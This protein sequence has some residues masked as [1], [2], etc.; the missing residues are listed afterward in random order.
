MNSYIS[1]SKSTVKTKRWIYSILFLVFFFSTFIISFNF[2]IDPYNITK[3]NILNIKY[4]FARDDRTE[5]LRYFKTLNKF[6][7]I[8]IGSSRVYSMNPILVNNILGGKTYNF[9]VG[10]ATIEDHLGVLKYLQKE[11]KMP[12]NIILGI[13]FYTFN[14]EIPPNKYFIKN[15]ELN[16]LSYSNYQEDYLSK[17]FSIDSFRASFKTLVNHIKKEGIARFDSLGWTGHYQD[18]SMRDLTQESIFIKKEADE[19]IEKIYS[20]FNYQHIDKKRIKYYEEIKNICIENHINLYLFNTPLHPILLKK[21]NNNK[22]TKDA[23][24]EFIAYMNTFDNFTDLYYHESIYK[25]LRNFIGATHT[26]ANAGDIILN[27]I[28]PKKISTD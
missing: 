6:D 3:Y 10:T 14:P 1:I 17:L 16:F 24:K 26:T 9:G 15:K 21:L 28:L 23:L 25:D 12:K 8:M 5:K 13:D 19:E 4:K 22:Q 20:N 18:Y 27:I 7:N 11:N 2:I